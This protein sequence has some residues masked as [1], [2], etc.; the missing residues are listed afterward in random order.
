MNTHDSQKNGKIGFYCTRCKRHLRTKICTIHGMQSVIVLDMHHHLQLPS[1]EAAKSAATASATNNA[2]PKTEPVVQSQPAMTQKSAAPQPK[3][4]TAKQPVTEKKPPVVES[5]VIEQKAATVETPVAEK[6][7]PKPTLPIN[8]LAEEFK[9]LGGTF[10]KAEVRDFT[11]T[12]GKVSAGSTDW[13]V[14][15]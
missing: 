2:A 13:P 9:A 5:A 4:V 6:A 1:G 14:R 15:C 12:G 3:P 11:L 10:R 7:A 8:S